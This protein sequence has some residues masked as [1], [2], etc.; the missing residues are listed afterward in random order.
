MLT[1]TL[2]LAGSLSINNIGLAIAGGIGGIDYASAAASIF[3]FSV[4]MLALGQAVGTNFIRLKSLHRVLRHPMVGNGALAHT[5]GLPVR[6]LARW[7]HAAGKCERLPRSIVS[8]RISRS[9]DQACADA[10]I[11]ELETYQR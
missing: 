5:R 9:G 6:G 10:L 2:F 4:V 3:C 8:A 1:E 7:P 11:R